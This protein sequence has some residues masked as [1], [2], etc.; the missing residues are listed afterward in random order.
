[1]LLGH[2]APFCSR[3]I[4]VEADDLL[5]GYSVTRHFLGLGHRRIAFLAGPPATPWTHE[6]FE[7]YRRALREAG[8]EVEEKLVFQAGAHL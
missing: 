7:G 1:M 8:L 3:F 6:R 2:T 4:N 5:A